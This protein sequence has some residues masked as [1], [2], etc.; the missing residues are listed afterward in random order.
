LQPIKFDQLTSQFSSVP[1]TAVASEVKGYFF[2]R[3]WLKIFEAITVI[4]CINKFLPQ[5]LNDLFDLFG[6]DIIAAFDNAI[7]ILAL[8]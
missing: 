4:R 1:I 6:N 2:T 8:T 5:H 7:V 3:K